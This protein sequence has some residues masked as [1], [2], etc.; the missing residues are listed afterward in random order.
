MPGRIDRSLGSA[1]DS[2]P[3]SVSSDLLGAGL[4]GLA[5][6]HAIV[7]QSTTQSTYR[8]ADRESRGEVV[9]LPFRAFDFDL[10][11]RVDLGQG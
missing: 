7:L 1:S 5:V 4:G 8:A 10:L 9:N 6:F 11:G 3:G 2:A